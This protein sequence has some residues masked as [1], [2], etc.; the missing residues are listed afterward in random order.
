MEKGKRRSTR[1]HGEK[2]KKSSFS[3]GIKKYSFHYRTIDIWTDLKEKVV[4]ANSV[5]MFKE[6]LDKYDYEDGTK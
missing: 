5:P 3:G 6:K 1:G 2:I 4:A